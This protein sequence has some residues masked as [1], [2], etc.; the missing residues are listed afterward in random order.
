MDRYIHIYTHS[1]AHTVCAYIH[2][3]AHIYTYINIDI[4]AHLNT[5]IYTY[6]KFLLYTTNFRFRISNETDSQYVKDQLELREESAT[7]KCC[8]IFVDD[9]YE[10]TIQ[11]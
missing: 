2:T 8:K 7:R 11:M 1:F 9:G 6:T 5:Y 3:R 4:I 10:K